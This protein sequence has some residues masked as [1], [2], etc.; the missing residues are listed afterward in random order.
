MSAVFSLVVTKVRFWSDAR[1]DLAAEYR[2]L[3]NHWPAQAA[4]IRE[5]IELSANRR[6]APGPRH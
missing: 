2:Y 5:V 6:A 4:A 3:K 1:A